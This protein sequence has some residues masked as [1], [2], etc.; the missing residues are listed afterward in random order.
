MTVDDQDDDMDPVTDPEEVLAS[1]IKDTAEYLIRHDRAEIKELLT[2]FQ[3]YHENYENDV[4]RLS[5][6]VETWIE[7]QVATEKKYRLT[8]SSIFFGNYSHLHL[9]PQVNQFDWKYF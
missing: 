8:I 7:E 6:L 9:F 4:V 1:K 3:D 5:Q 2:K